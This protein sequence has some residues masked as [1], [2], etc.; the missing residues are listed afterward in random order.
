MA[1]TRQTQ[2]RI[3]QVGEEV[4]ID[5]DDAAVRADEIMLLVSIFGER[6]RGKDVE[7]AREAMDVGE[8]YVGAARSLRCEIE[9]ELERREDGFRVRA[10]DQT[11]EEMLVGAT[12]S[13]F[14]EFIFPRDGYPSRAPPFF[15]LRAD[16]LSNSHLSALTAH[17]DQMWNTNVAR[18]GGPIVYEWT[19]WLRTDALEE[20]L[21]DSCGILKL[22][23]RALGWAGEDFELDPRGIVMARDAREAELSI[24]RADAVA[25]RRDFLACGDNTCGVCLSDD[26]SGHDLRR[27][28]GA[29]G[30][31]FCIEC[32]TR[33][34]HVHVREGTVLKL[35]CPDQ[36]CSCSI[37]PHVLKEVLGDQEFVRYETL[38]LSKTLDAMNDVVYCPRCEYPVIEDEE[39]RLGRCVKCLYAFCTLC[40]ASFHP[41]SEC[42]NIEQKLAVLEG[43]KRGNSQMSIEALRKYRE[44]IADASAEAYV[45]R[46]GK[47][48]PECRHAVVKNAGCNKIT[49]VCG[50]FFCWTCGKDLIGDGYSHY[51]N[52]NSE[53]GKSACQL[54][55][56]D[57]ITAW[58]N[59]MAELNPQRQGHGHINHE[60]ATDIATCIRCKA[61]NAMFDRNNHVRCWACN[62][63]FCAACKKIVTKTS[64]HY[65]PGKCKQHG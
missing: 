38:L 1:L 8:T 37:E 22:S 7:A 49:C 14:L 25:R 4:E 59:E 10:T 50:C 31:F 48:C 18:G 11:S 9:V 63:S 36:E 64:Y 2:E 13:V 3:A 5:D 20:V 43:R 19:E 57:T 24:L 28:S 29:C 39:M 65:G 35:V 45:A 61:A 42:L 55:N 51:R 23:A 15:V 46:V 6:A 27:V 12:P 16:W 21:L 60:R 47:S 30:H 58:E 62:S 17:L 41:G 40:R 52:V 56:L 53:P 44:E 32:V 26:V 54:F 33:M 34:A